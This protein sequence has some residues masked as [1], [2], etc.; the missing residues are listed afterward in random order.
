MPVDAVVHH[1]APV[2]W[3]QIPL[4]EADFTQ[5]GAR[6]LVRSENRLEATVCRPPSHVHGAS[7]PANLR[8]RLD[9]GHPRAIPG[10]PM[11][12]RKASQA[13]TDHHAVDSVPTVLD[14][15]AI[16]PT[17]IR[18]RT[19]FV[20]RAGAGRSGNSIGATA[21]IPNPGILIET[22]RGP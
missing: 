22:Y 13:G 21:A 20:H 12:G 18:G 8:G 17:T 2:K 16:L 4:P 5:K 10:Q 19:A 1:R 15:A 14:H 3:H 7:P 11:R 9:H 6:L